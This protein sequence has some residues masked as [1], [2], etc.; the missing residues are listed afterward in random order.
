MGESYFVLGA[1]G[2]I[3]RSI[4]E[5]LAREGKHVVAG[6]RSPAAYA[7]PR[8]VNVVSPFERPEHFRPVLAQSL[9]VVHAAS[10][11]TPA[12]SMAKPQIDGNLVTTLALL[13]ALQD[14]ADRRLVFLSS[15]GTLYGDHA[16][17]ASEDSPMRPRSYHG[18]GKAAAE[19]FI[20]AWSAQY[21]ATAVILRP[22]NVY[23]PGQ[24]S[25]PG[26]GLIPTAF[27]CL[28]TGEAL[29]VFGAGDSVRDYLYIDDLVDLCELCL[30]SKLPP[31]AHVFNASTEVPTS[32]NLLLQLI[33]QV[34]GRFLLRA[35][36]RARP[37]DV[38]Q[39]VPDSKAARR[40]FAWQ[41]RV[42]LVEGL[43][44]AWRWFQANSQ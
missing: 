43:A 28:Q 1:G 23:G 4:C 33:E 5:Q 20:Q 29:N 26:F 12:S 24:I 8:I 22:S 31:Q 40:A 38:G 36:Q 6:T 9:A 15:G 11:S 17:L 27:R 14:H 2:F 13:E 32:V 35:H 30:Q 19:H 7:H 18:A 34:T 21:A 10:V 42:S 41:P 44:E 37:V 16:G 25:R 39:V 3:G